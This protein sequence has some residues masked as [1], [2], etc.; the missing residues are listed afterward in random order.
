MYNV[1]FYKDKNGIE[2]VQE[3]IDELRFKND[4][5]SKIKFR[6][7]IEYIDRLRVFG[8]SMNEPY[9]KHIDGD[10]WELRPSNGRVFFVCWYKG[11]FVLL[12]YFVK[13]TQKT[14]KREIE[15]AKRELEDIKERR[16]FID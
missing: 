5:D 9:I 1:F 2:P 11:S 10:I 15:K 16:L 3:V 14:P 7:L 13:K 12:H 8:L 4:K 6:K